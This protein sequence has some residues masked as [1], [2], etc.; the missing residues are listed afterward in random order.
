MPELAFLLEQLVQRPIGLRLLDKQHFVWIL[1]GPLKERLGSTSLGRAFDG[2]AVFIEHGD[3]LG[4]QI[5]PHRVV[6]F[7]AA[8]ATGGPLA[9]RL[10]GA[11]DLALESALF[12]VLVLRCSFEPEAFFL[13][14]LFAGEADSAARGTL[15]LVLARELV[16]FV[17]LAFA[18][19]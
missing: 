14:A 13:R 5:V 6:V 9:R 18:E 8:F 11:L 10:T 17:A 3:E 2:L 16:A 1:L 19:R 4:R 15:C 12:L 7:L